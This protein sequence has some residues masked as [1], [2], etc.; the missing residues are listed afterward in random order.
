MCV[1]INKRLIYDGDLNG[2]VGRRKN[3]ERR[4]LGRWSIGEK[5]GE[6]ERL[7]DHAVAFDFAL[8][9]TY[10]EKKGNQ[11][12][13]YMSGGR[14]SQIDIF[15]CRRRHLSEIE[16]RIK[17][18]RLKEKEELRKEFKVK[19]LQEIQF[20]CDVQTWW[21]LNNNCILKVGKEVLGKS[22]GKRPPKREELWWWNAEVQS[23]VKRKKKWDFMGRP[24]DK[25]TYHLE[26]AKE[27]WKVF[28]RNLLNEESP[29]TLY[30]NGEENEGVVQDISKE[31]ESVLR[32]MKMGK[33]VGTYRILV[34]T[35]R[36]LGKKGIDILWDL[37]KKLW[38][39]E[40]IS[41]NWRKSILVPI[42][43]GK[44]DVQY[45]RNYRGIKILSHTMK[46][47][48]KIVERRIR[49]E[50]EIGE[51]QFC[52]LPGRST[53]DTIFALKQLVERHRESVKVGPL[54]K[55]M[56]EC[57]L[58]WF[59]H[60][61]RRSD[62]YDGKKIGKLVIEGKGKRGRPKMRWEDKVKEDLNQRG[63]KREEALD[64]EK[65]K[66]TY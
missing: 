16:Q 63:L 2:H 27:R 10:F 58:R 51:R 33:A 3:A 25:E 41:D 36:G 64:R 48:E 54:S 22:S 7:V 24:E 38:Q 55:K 44:G 28:F 47:W 18:G 21:L 53:T 26:R 37:M 11:L 20:P 42:F 31:V 62:N 13:T 49:K 66:K 65:W 8:V 4:I 60:L 52:F 57:R 61:E 59:G 32:K 19:V 14:S 5:N 12:V 50:S 29:R 43:K 6:R 45:S 40:K 1:P 9:N 56:Q 34:E 30:E 46:I 35:W 23:A 39:Q 15:L 17:L